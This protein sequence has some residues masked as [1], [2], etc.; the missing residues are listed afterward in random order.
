MLIE[1]QR[2]S[3]VAKIRL[4]DVLQWMLARRALEAEVAGE[5][6]RRLPPATVARIE[7]NLFYQQAAIGGDD[8]AGFLELDVAFHKLL[9]D[10]LALARVAEVLEVAAG[11]PRPGAAAAAARAGPDGLHPR[12]ASRHPRGGHRPPRAPGRGGDARAR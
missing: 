7:R 6:A 4:D 3:Y 11:A 12:R 8:F 1:P 2:G 10:G 5:A 9:T